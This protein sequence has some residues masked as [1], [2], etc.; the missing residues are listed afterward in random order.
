ML[1]PTVL[2]LVQVD[3]I[4]QYENLTPPTTGTKKNIPAFAVLPPALAEV[5]QTTDMTH[6]ALLIATIQ[7]IKVLT[8]ASPVAAA[9]EGL[10]YNSSWLVFLLS[11]VDKFIFLK[12]L[13]LFHILNELVLDTVYDKGIMLWFSFGLL[14][15]PTSYGWKIISKFSLP[16]TLFI[17]SMTFT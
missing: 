12:Y 14:T 4:A 17:H 10:M 15:I 5:Y 13:Y 9:P 16:L 11:G 1:V 6:A 8:P 3:T 2:D 7:H